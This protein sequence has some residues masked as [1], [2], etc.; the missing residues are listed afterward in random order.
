MNVVI[1]KSLT[2][3]LK[4]VIISLCMHVFQSVTT[5]HSHKDIFLGPRSRRQNCS[6]SVELVTVL[7][8]QLMR[9]EEPQKCCPP[10]PGVLGHGGLTSW[11]SGPWH[12]GLASESQC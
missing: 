8:K 5:Q 9:G 2:D 6:H 3:E 10:W 4:G 12:F 7:G 11:D 1:I